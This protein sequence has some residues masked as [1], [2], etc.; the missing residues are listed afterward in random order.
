MDDESGE[1]NPY[2]ECVV[3][4]AEKIENAKNPYGTVVNTK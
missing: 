2:R 3:N 1:V 4:N